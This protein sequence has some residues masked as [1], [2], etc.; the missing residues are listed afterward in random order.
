[1]KGITTLVIIWKPYQINFRFYPLAALELTVLY[2]SKNFQFVEGKRKLYYKVRSTLNFLRPLRTRVL[3]FYNC[4]L[5]FYLKLIQFITGAY[6]RSGLYWMITHFSSFWK[7]TFCVFSTGTS[8]RGAEHLGTNPMKSV[9]T[10]LTLYEC[11]W[12]KTKFKLS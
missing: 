7:K 4:F 2:I 3:S 8:T 1:M 6:V 5:E 9:Y 12:R 10:M 11:M